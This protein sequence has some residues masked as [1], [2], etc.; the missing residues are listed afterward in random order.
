[1]EPGVKGIGKGIGKGIKME[2]FVRD[3]PAIIP[4]FLQN[5]KWECRSIPRFLSSSLIELDETEAHQLLP[6]TRGFDVT[7]G[8]RL[9]A[10]DDAA[11]IR[12]SA[13]EL[14]PL[15]ELAVGNASSRKEDI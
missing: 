10:H 13:K 12:A 2:T 7:D 4:S 11:C 6:T 3:V 5:G 8:T 1:M 9:G 15:Q 14:D